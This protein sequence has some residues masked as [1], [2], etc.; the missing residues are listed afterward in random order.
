[1]QLSSLF[2]ALNRYYSLS[3]NREYTVKRIKQAGYCDARI[4]CI[5][6]E[7][8]EKEKHRVFVVIITLKRP[9][10]K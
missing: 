4:E 8:N 3:F 7:V 2:V 5:L 9:T 6:L 1:L 10:D